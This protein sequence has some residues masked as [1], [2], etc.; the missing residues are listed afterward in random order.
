MLVTVFGL[1]VLVT[2]S[3]SDMSPARGS[4]IICAELMMQ[5]NKSFSIEE[6]NICAD[7]EI[8][9]SC[10][11]VHCNSAW[12]SFGS[13]KNKLCYCE[14]GDFGDIKLTN[15]SENY[16]LQNSGMRSKII[17]WKLSL[18]DNKQN[19]LNHVIPYAI[20]PDIDDASKE[21]I[22]AAIN[23]IEV[24]SCITFMMMQPEEQDYLHFVNKGRCNS[25]LGRKGGRQEISITFGC[26]TKGHI[27]HLLMHALGF[28]HQHWRPDRDQYISIHWHNIANDELHNFLMVRE[29]KKKLTTPF[30]VQSIMHYDSY[31]YSKNGLPTITDKNGSLLATQ[32]GISI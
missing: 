18:W 6:V 32:V 19:D 26:K 15:E 29:D 12:C 14:C 5:P 7:K 20:S 1:F 24:N 13:K 25:Y 23:D 21:E 3:C 30:D 28:L 17:K 16:L 31:A 2:N 9:Y 10:P 11:P 27:L 8:Q 22:Y 4:G